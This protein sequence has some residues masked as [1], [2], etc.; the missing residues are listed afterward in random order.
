MGGS[1]RPGVVLLLAGAC[2]L[3]ALRGRRGVPS[4]RRVFSRRGRQG[5]AEAPRATFCQFYF[6]R[7]VLRHNRQRE[8]RSREAGGELMKWFGS[9]FCEESLQGEETV[10][11]YKRI[12]K[13]K[14]NMTVTQ[15]DIGL[16]L[17]C[18]Y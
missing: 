18:I 16:T 14:T 17:V 8:A 9:L 11:G 1:K 5:V 2:L 4:T 10:H 6:F 12:P 3:G 13:G 15:R 7:R